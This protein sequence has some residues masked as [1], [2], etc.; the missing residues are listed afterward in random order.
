MDLSSSLGV[1]ETR[2]TEKTDLIDE[3]KKVIPLDVKAPGVI[4]IGAR[5]S[6]KSTI[7]EAM[8]GVPL[9]RGVGATRRPLKIK[10]FSD[11]TCTQ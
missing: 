8:T 7:L 1:L 9:P 4:A 5:G 2:L 10:I 3:M 6:G 11:P